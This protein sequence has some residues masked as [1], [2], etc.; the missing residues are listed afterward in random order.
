MIVLTQIYPLVIELREKM[1]D[2]EHSYPLS[3]ANWRKFAAF[4]DK[5]PTKEMNRRSVGAIASHFHEIISAD[6]E[7]SASQ[8]LPREFQFSTL[9]EPR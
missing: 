5:V 6:G 2:Y 8:T 4:I 7:H 3:P 1:P 9:S